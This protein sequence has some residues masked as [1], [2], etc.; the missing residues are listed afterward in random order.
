VSFSTP[1]SLNRYL[2]R[3]E[4]GTVKEI[5]TP[6]GVPLE[7]TLASVGDRIWAFFID[8]LVIAAG[9][10]ALLLGGMVLLFASPNLYLAI[11]LLGLFIMRS[12]Y[13]AI[14]EVRWRGCTIGKRV[15]GI[16]VVD[17]HGGPLT[18][19]AVLARNLT[20]EVEFWI[21]LLVLS[22]PKQLLPDLPGWVTPFAIAWLFI[23]LLFPLFN[24]ERL[25]LGDLIAGTMVVL[26]PR[27]ML[28]QDLAVRRPKKKGA[29]REPYRFTPEQLDIYGIFELQVLE[30]VLRG[31]GRH[32]PRPVEVVAEK[33]KAKIDWPKEEWNVDARAFLQDFYAAQRERLERRMLLGERK[34]KKSR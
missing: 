17:R 13:F 7:L 10:L 28:L 16:R 31:D 23:L 14:L 27:E 9:T 6:E 21:P 29:R 8:L 18:A 30:G 20:R 24:R 22:F 11:V 34:E 2:A 32:D 26:T 12:F 15:A 1:A 4:R 3:R 25:R 33:I 19:E 5:V